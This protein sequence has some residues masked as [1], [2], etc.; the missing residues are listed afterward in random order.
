MFILIIRRFII[1]R[2]YHVNASSIT[3]SEC[4]FLYCKVYYVIGKTSTS[5]TLSS[6]FF[7]STLALFYYINTYQRM[8]RVREAPNKYQRRS[9]KNT[10]K[11][12]HPVIKWK[13]FTTGNCNDAYL[14]WKTRERQV[15]NKHFSVKPR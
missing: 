6:T 3:P 10:R 14:M 4:H 8:N 15:I 9:H 2:S 7:E 12:I 1:L 11:V 5:I 13:T